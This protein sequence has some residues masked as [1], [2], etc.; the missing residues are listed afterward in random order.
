MLQVLYEQC[1]QLVLRGT[2]LERRE[3]VLEFQ[4]REVLE[5]LGLLIDVEI[6][7]ESRQLSL[8][9]INQNPVLAKTCLGCAGLKNLNHAERSQHSHVVFQ[10]ADELLDH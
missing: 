5:D 1:P 3:V 7:K 2:D 6:L 4:H 9:E 10:L 8:N